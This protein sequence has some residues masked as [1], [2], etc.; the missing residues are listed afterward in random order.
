MDN[1]KFI[2][3]SG[4][5]KIYHQP[6]FPWNSREFPK[7]SATFLGGFPSLSTREPRLFNHVWSSWHL[8][9]LVQDPN[10]DDEKTGW[11]TP[12]SPS[13]HHFLLA[14]AKKTKMT[15]KKCDVWLVGWVLCVCSGRGVDL[16]DFMLFAWAFEKNILKYPR[17]KTY[18]E[19]NVFFPRECNTTMNILQHTS[20][21]WHGHFQ[22]GT[23]DVVQPL[24]PYTQFILI[25]QQQIA[26]PTLRLKDKIH[27]CWLNICISHKPILLSQ[28]K[29]LPSSWSHL[30]QLLRT[31]KWRF[32][33]YI[34]S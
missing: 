15:P 28:K 7:T 6:R 11:D 10:F 16:D 17:S 31:M 19:L 26:T 27:P 13:R 23:E 2:D 29:K 21:S 12:N 14:E 8:V 22:H 32:I 18:V 30:T 33:N 34:V 4:Q 20:S 1:S 24:M 3:P 25:Y 9:N 5:I